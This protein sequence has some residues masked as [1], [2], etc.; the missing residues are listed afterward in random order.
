MPEGRSCP[1]CG[2]ALPD[3][4]AL[5]SRCSLELA[6]TK[7]GPT[8]PASP[9]PRVAQAAPAIEGYRVLGP[10]GAGGMGAV[11]LAEDLTLGRRVAI[12]VIAATRAA[13]REARERFLREARA[14]ATV[15][16]PHVVRLY[17]FGE[18][19]GAAHLVMEYVR[20]ED[21]ASRLRRLGRLP[22]DGALR[23]AGQIASALE[24][25][26][27]KGIVHRD[28]KPQNVL[29]DVRDEVRLGDFG[30]ARSVDH[31]LEAALTQE[32]RIVGTP[33]YL[34]PEQGRG[35]ATDLRSDIYSLGILL[36]EMLAGERPFGGATPLAVVAQHLS[37]PLPSL[38][39]RRPETPAGVLHLIAAMTDKDPR[40]RPQSYADLRRALEEAVGPPLRW[41]AGSPFRGLSAYEFEHA[42]IFFG[43]S[44]ATSDVLAAVRAQAAAG[45]AF[46]LVLGMSG[47]GKSS[48]LRAGVM[49]RLVEPGSIGDV[50]AWR[51]AVLRP[52]ECSGDLFDGLAAALFREDALPEMGADGT[53][54]SELASVLRDSPRSAGALVKAGLSQ[55]AAPLKRT[56]GRDGAADV[57]LALL[58]DQMEEL[59]TL[60]RVSLDGRRGFIDA[61]SALARCGR[62]VVLATLRSD[63][64]ARCEELPELMA[65]KEGAGQYHLL[66][67]TPAEIAQMI[68]QPARAAGLSFEPDPGTLAGLDE[69]LR[70]AAAHAASLPLLEF[71]LEELFQRRTA[72]GV[73][74]QAAYHE[75]GGIEGALTRRA[76]SAFASLPASVQAALPE[77]LGALVRVDP[78]EGQ[79]FSRSYAPLGSF[80]SPGARALLDAFVGAR[81]FVADHADDGRAV[82]SIAHEAL[83]RS[84]PRLRDWLEQNRELLRVRGRVSLAAALWKEQGRPSDLLLAEGKPLE[85]ALPLL[86]ACGLSLPPAE[87][88]FLGL[89]QSRAGRRRQARL[90]MN[91]N[92][93]LLLVGAAVVISI[94]L[95]IVVPAFAAMAAFQDRLL[96][97]PLRLLIAGSNLFVRVS[98]LILVALFFLVRRRPRLPEFIRSGWALAITSG[99]AL[100]VTQLVFLL[101]AVQMTDM[102][103]S[104]AAAAAANQLRRANAAQLAL[105][106]SGATIAVNELLAQRTLL[107]GRSEPEARRLVPFTTLL[108][109]DALRAAGDVERARTFYEEAARSAGATND[110][111][112]S[113]RIAA[114]ARNALDGSPK[115]GSAPVSATGNPG[116]RPTE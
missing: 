34:P 16:H 3:G 63:F 87:R 31:P 110:P 14:M 28:I 116:Q 75:M 33:H 115:A 111:V 29:L 54:S 114:A 102:M 90:L 50:R 30:L 101:S 19:A 17:A 83:L 27:E 5:C 24:A 12:K 9:G 106:G 66:P 113:A 93:V 51:R 91:A 71:A 70:D 72:E 85:E 61:L 78:A 79:P 65:L 58:V 57:R 97:L 108:L 46:V 47:S 36:Y 1:Q 77:V 45:R 6:A 98:P 80:G 107:L 92:S 42:P 25:A 74:T 52:A 18:S 69:T 11:F 20:G 60:E 48:L 73:L 112:M 76:E 84:W 15:E 100:L 44:R 21:L 104:S 59:F 95:W 13:D 109:A 96:N 99:L 103:P 22:V 41:T 68:R 55:V 39:E 49:P 4:V 67:P 88:E 56:G 37:A 32:G 10:L 53:R 89:S 82:V 2:Q 8:E 64:Y 35:E 62:V 86:Q 40:R 38:R 105:R 23:I 7:A 26:W 43:R 81:L 94:Y